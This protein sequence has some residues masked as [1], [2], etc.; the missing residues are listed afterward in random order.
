MGAAPEVVAPLLKLEGVVGPAVGTPSIQVTIP[1]DS[2]AHS[3][4]LHM[5]HCCFTSTQAPDPLTE[6]SWNP[7]PHGHTSNARSSKTPPA[8]ATRS[9]MR[10]TGQ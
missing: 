9:P 5:A 10:N 8:A 6:P 3:S 1:V 4:S 2:D 7:V